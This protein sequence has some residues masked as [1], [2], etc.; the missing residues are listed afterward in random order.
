MTTI[1][2][3][4]LPFPYAIDEIVERLGVS[5]GAAQ[6]MLREACASGDVRSQRTLIDLRGR[7]I[8][9]AEATEIVKPS[10]WPKEQVDLAEEAP[11]LEYVVEVD[12]DDFRYWLDQQAQP[13]RPG[14]IIEA[15][16]AKAKTEAPSLADWL[17]QGPSVSH[18]WDGYVGHWADETWVH[19]YWAAN[20]IGD[21][22]AIASAPAQARLRKLCASGVIRAVISDGL[23]EPERIPASQWRSEDVDLTITGD[24]LIAVSES[25]L[26]D[27]LDQQSTAGG[28][29]S[30]I[31]RLLAGL[32]PTGVP[33]RGAAP[34]EPMRAALLKLDP[35]LE[36]LD[37]KTLKTAIDSFNRQLGNTRKR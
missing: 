1:R 14:D 27:W 28:K 26:R 4:W 25:D 3:D 11:G 36:P 15:K 35:S 22:L 13:K 17:A 21:K 29:Q 34:R 2:D 24:R 5:I 6:R 8:V 31:I 37:L 16:P 9:A 30:R 32:Y 20:Q 7:Q 18:S 10:D 33:N 19:F 12:P 23:E